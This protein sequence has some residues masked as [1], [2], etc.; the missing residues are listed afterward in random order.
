MNGYGISHFLKRKETIALLLLIVI[1]VNVSMLT[2][3]WVGY[4]K[5][6]AASANRLDQVL[7]RE[8]AV[9]KQMEGLVSANQVLKA[10]LERLRQ[11]IQTQREQLERV[12]E[13]LKSSGR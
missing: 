8:Q 6:A 3:I 4:E 10:E 13:Q 5:F 12:E 1:A 9:S 7:A 2:F 11:V